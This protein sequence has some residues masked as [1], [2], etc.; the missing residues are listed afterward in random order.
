MGT[1]LEAF[2]STC[3]N[4]LAALVEERVVLVLGVKD[5]LKRLQRKMGKIK[6]VLEDAERKRIEDSTINIWL[7]ELKDVMYDADDIIDLCKYETSNLLEDHPSSS[8]NPPVCC[9]TSLFSCSSTIPVRHEIG[10]R[11]KSLNDRMEEI[12]KDKLMFTLEHVRSDDQHVVRA[13][14]R[15]TSPL[16]DADVV[17]TKIKTAADELVKRILSVKGKQHQVFAIAGMGGI[18]KTTLAQRVYNDPAIKNYFSVIAWTCVSKRYSEIVLLKE[19]VR[20]CKGDYGRAETIAELQQVLG[21]LVAGKQFFLVLDDVWQSDVWSNLL[22][23][24]L[25]SGEGSGRILITTRDQNVAKGM[26]AIHI[27]QVEQLPIDAGWQLLCKR[28]YLNKE[29][30]VLSLRDVGI[31]IV[32]KCGGLPLAIKIVA[33]LLATKDNNKR[34]WEKI[35]KSHAWSMSGLPDELRGALYLSY[36]DLSPQLKQCFLYFSLYPEDAKMIRE[37]LI[38][39][40]VAEGFIKEKGDGQIME[41]T[42]EEYYNELVRR[43]LLQLDLKFTDGSICRMHDLLRSLAQNLSK[44]ESFYG[45]PQLLNPT[46]MSKIRR[47][48]II[49]KGEI[50]VNSP[51]LETKYPCLRTVISFGIPQRVENHLLL[52]LPYLRILDLTEA[53]IESISDSL[54]DLIHLRLLD[55]DYT[56]ISDLPDS[57]GRLTNLQMLNLMY[58]KNLHAL[59]KGLTRLCNLRRLGIKDTPLCDVPKGIGRLHL[60]NDLEGFLVTNE[61]VSGEMQAGW[62]LKEL[63]SL[64]QLRKLHIKKL[65][66]TI[67]GV[68]VLERKH[69]LRRLILQCT[70]QAEQASVQQSYSEEETNRIEKIFEK[71]S[72]SPCIEYLVIDGF[73]GRRYPGYIATSLSRLTSLHL[74]DCISCSHLPPLGQLPYLR[75]LKIIRALA[76]V[77]ISLEFLGNGV[78]VGLDVATAFPKLEF[79][80]FQQMP[81]WEHWSLGEEI[82]KNASIG[83]KIAPSSSPLLLPRL[84][85]LELT[86]CPKLRALPE[87]LK[88]ATVLQRFHIEGAHSLRAVENIPS[89][90]QWLVIEGSNNIERVTNL[91]QLRE[92]QVVRSPAL[93][94]VQSLDALQILY[95]EDE[96]MEYL[97][98]WV[99]GVLHQRQHL[100]NNNDLELMLHCNLRV[101]ERCQ[102]GHQDWSIIQ[103]F[104]KVRACT[105]DR[106]GYLEYTKSPFSYNSS[107]LE[108]RGRES[109]TEEGT[110]EEGKEGAE[111]G[112]E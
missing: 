37:D 32:E 78:R 65:E 59:P 42:A 60:L 46:A 8:S 3:V 44:D 88:H 101:L 102:Q 51:I 10:C 106:S 29:E 33:G 87:G 69:H 68:S 97:P 47:L 48:S 76:V 95:V 54:G 50:V 105:A 21:D 111:E 40:W 81:N 84:L 17:G 28:A 38:R 57:L 90:S 107:L 70:L 92:L 53:T 61:C 11:I 39:L 108:L 89:L 23:V 91:P 26:G 2:V 31:Q 112:V 4:N 55:L 16:L 41:D 72:L 34:E 58:C 82:Q 98:E 80:I 103:R 100:D 99:S 86:D 94:C 74:R 9:L 77:T 49:K 71:L 96:S 83:E 30:D 56:N 7:N 79:L 20:S 6:G 27:H 19:I 66:R 63:E 45:D 13:T 5:E 18:G 14:A 36:E 85:Y 25:Q 35:L 52:R 12:Y 104:S 64:N 75:Y 15:M 24:P 110:K 43:S 1:V 109:G 93:S 62:D 67:D 22:R 73:F